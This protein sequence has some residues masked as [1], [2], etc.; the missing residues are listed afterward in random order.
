MSVLYFFDYNSGDISHVS[1]T[2]CDLLCV[3]QTRKP[4][5]EVA[6]TTSFQLKVEAKF[7]YAIWF[8]PASVMEFGFNGSA[9]KFSVG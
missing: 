7:H 1:K 9:R 3:V 4:S 6:P 5:L 8:E 2:D